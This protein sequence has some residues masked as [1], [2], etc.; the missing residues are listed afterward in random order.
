ML[1]RDSLKA[2]MS[3]FLMSG[4]FSEQSV[5]SVP[6]SPNNDARNRAQFDANYCSSQSFGVS[7][8]SH[9]YCQFRGNF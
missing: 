3:I 7:F 1:E 9:L 4:I 8:S 2:E 6:S 5:G